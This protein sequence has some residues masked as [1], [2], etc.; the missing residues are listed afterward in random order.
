MGDSSRDTVS[1]PQ[2]EPA[3]GSTVAGLA[4]ARWHQCSSA[5]PTRVPRQDAS[6]VPVPRHDANHVGMPT[7][8]LRQGAMPTMPGLPDPLCSEL[9]LGCPLA[10]SS[11]IPQSRPR[12]LSAL[13]SPIPPNPKT[14]RKRGKISPQTKDLLYIPTSTP[15]QNTAKPSPAANPSLRTRETDIKFEA[16]ARA[17]RMRS[18]GKEPG[19]RRPARG[20]RRA[21]RQEK[22]ARAARLALGRLESTTSPSG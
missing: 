16:R 4:G 18:C 11:D 21:D 9:V 7:L 8:P 6:L 17:G 10:A 1:C 19:R 12:A 2:D 15:L 13:L 20:R 5:I 14:G 22:S 3:P